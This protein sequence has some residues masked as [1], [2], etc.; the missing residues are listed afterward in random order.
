MLLTCFCGFFY[1]EYF[2]SINKDKKQAIIYL[3]T[4]SGQ[5]FW[6]TFNFT[7]GFSDI[8]QPSKENQGQ[9]T[10]HTIYLAHKLFYFYQTK[11]F[12]L[13]ST[14]NN[15]DKYIQ[16]F[17]RNLTLYYKGILKFVGFI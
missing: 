2:Y 8:Y 17:H 16:V 12:I 15:C 6:S 13:S 11:E 5:L 14:I 1:P 10:V 9:I 3:I 7:E 4:T